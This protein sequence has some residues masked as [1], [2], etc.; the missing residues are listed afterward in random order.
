MHTHSVR[1]EWFDVRNA[2]LASTCTE[3]G[4][5]LQAIIKLAIRFR[6][7]LP[8]YYTLIVRSLC[9]LEGVALRIDPDFS[10]VNA[11]IPIILRRMLTDTRPAAVN[12]LR[13]LL[14][15]NGQQLRVGMLEGLLR[16][17]SVEAGK[18]SASESP[19]SGVVLQMEGDGVKAPG[20]NGASRNGATASSNGT[21][22]SSQTSYIRAQV[23]SA[24]D[25][26]MGNG[27]SRTKGGSAPQNGATAGST[28]EQAIRGNGVVRARSRLRR[29][30]SEAT[31]AVLLPSVQSTDEEHQ[32]VERSASVGVATRN[33]A[34]EHMHA[35]EVKNPQGGSMSEVA[36][37][38]Q[39][40][41]A[42]SLEATVLKMVLSA[43][44]AGVRRVVLESDMKVCI[45]LS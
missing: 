25:A 18:G 32:V 38:D 33:G 11:A 6:F 16:N 39:E 28:K 3:C 13:E 34:Q 36:N 4:V 22:G 15:D 2:G 20:T 31:A 30:E 17:Y 19:A 23:R 40:P 5:C 41:V 45:P 37:V 44:A 27:R 1:G 7:R 42:E 43:R 10:I 9:S 21:A 26:V 12:L 8:P 29:Q 24:E 35:H 14:L